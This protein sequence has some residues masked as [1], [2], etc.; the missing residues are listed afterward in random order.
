MCTII[1]EESDWDQSGE[2]QATER[3][4]NESLL[5]LSEVG[6]RWGARGG[7]EMLSYIQQ[8]QERHTLDRLHGAVPH[9]AAAD[10][11][12]PG[13]GDGRRRV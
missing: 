10:R 12:F 9:L 8:S 13:D 4:R 3:S 1:G 11:F 5:E 6:Q 2:V 7:E